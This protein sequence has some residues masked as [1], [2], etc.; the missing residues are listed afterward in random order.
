MHD[1]LDRTVREVSFYGLITERFFARRNATVRPHL[2]GRIL[3]SGG[4][5]DYYQPPNASAKG[6]GQQRFAPLNR[7]PDNANFDK[8]RRLVCGRSSRKAERRSVDDLPC[9][10]IRNRI[11]RI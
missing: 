9:E 4:A 5:P 11:C 8:A 1:P 7:W 10:A 6:T 2:L 3:L